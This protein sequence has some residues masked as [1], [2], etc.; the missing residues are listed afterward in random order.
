MDISLATKPRDVNPVDRRFRLQAFQSFSQV[1]ITAAQKVAV[2]LGRGSRSERSESPLC[3]FLLDLG[4]GQLLP[5]H[6]AREKRLGK[7]PDVLGSVMA[8]DHHFSVHLQVEERG[9]DIASRGPTVCTSLGSNVIFK[10]AHPQG[11]LCQ[12]AQDFFRTPLLS[13]S[14]FFAL[15]FHP[16][17]DLERDSG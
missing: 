8:Y 4:F 14:H 13:A 9:G 1:Q 5:L 10:F 11:S 3:A 12:L 15:A 16:P 17:Q 2:N 6:P 7:A